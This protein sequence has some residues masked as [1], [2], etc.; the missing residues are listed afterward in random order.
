MPAPA[1]RTLPHA[2]F[3]RRSW[4]AVFGR[5]AAAVAV[6]AGLVVVPVPVVGD[7]FADCAAAQGQ[8]RVTIVVDPGT[9]G[10]APRGPEAH[11]VTVPQG[12]T[13]AEVLAERA[14]QLGRAHPRYASSGLLCGIDGYP[15]S[16]CG[17]HVS[18]GYEYWA[19]W[20]ASDG[21]WRYSSQGPAYRKMH[22]GDVEGWR[23]VRGSGGPGDPPP[24]R[25]PTS[26]CPSGS[27]GPTSPSPTAPP[28]SS[29][30]GG[31]SGG[32]A[33]AAPT[34]PP[35]GPAPAPS[36]APQESPPGPAPE[37]QQ[38][39]ESDDDDPA[40]STG[41]SDDSDESED[42]ARASAGRAGEGSEHPTDGRD[43]G[44]RSPAA[45]EANPDVADLDEDDS[46]LA[47]ANSDE[48]GVVPVGA[49]IVLLA[50]FGL[51]ASALWR[52]RRRSI[53]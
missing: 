41:T 9:V 47:M 45:D 43:T 23:F 5:A 30:S 21:T 15:S 7:L 16:G 33:G 32:G 13:G 17:Q 24:R 34:A 27:P 29:S 49:L 31:G 53:P 28:S 35:P 6:A 12:A 3:G 48:A 25:A 26:A 52:T 19:Y 14:R 2:G 46:E 36:L 51:G 18:G 20:S 10:G 44:G 11:C 50:A 4:S 40:G 38:G 39:G 22:D 8:I 1:P 37:G 42:R